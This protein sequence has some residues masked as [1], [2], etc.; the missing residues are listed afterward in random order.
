MFKLAPFTLFFAPLVAAQ[1]YSYDLAL[2]AF[3]SATSTFSSPPCNLFTCGPNQV[4][5]N[6][7]NSTVDIGQWV[8]EPGPCDEDWQAASSG[9]IS[10]QGRRNESLYIDWSAN[11]GTQLMSEVRFRYGNVAVNPWAVQLIIHSQ[12]AMNT[13]PVAV[14]M[15]DGSQFYAFTFQEPVT[16][17]GVE[18]I[19]YGL[20]SRDEGKTCFVAVSNVEAWTGA[21]PNPI[22][23]G[24]SDFDSSAGASKVITIGGL[25]AM[26]LLPIIAGILCI[27]LGGWFLHSRRKN[28]LARNSIVARDTELRKRT[29][30]G[31]SREHR[32][33]D[34]EE[35]RE[36][37]VEAGPIAT[38]A[39]V[40]NNAV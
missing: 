38:T 9:N 40:W 27:G 24:G 17:S 23:T 37:H 26:I 14:P 21:P 33:V 39:N 28:L 32:L 10:P 30:R 2:G 15:M 34:E 13:N 4:I 29:Q 11:F 5:I 6:P 18:L 12:T 36:P 19:F 31:E 1:S 16:A 25:V 3:V 8:S 7:P 20:Q 22:P 35:E